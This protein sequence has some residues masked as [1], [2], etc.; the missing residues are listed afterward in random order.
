[1]AQLGMVGLGRM[2]AN[3]VRRLMRDGHDCVVYDVNPDA[4]KELAGE[5]A[6][7]AVSLDELAE[8]LDAPRARLGHGPGRR[9]HREHGR[10]R[11]P[12]CSRSRRRDH[13]RRQL[14][15]PR[16][17]PPRR[18]SSASEGIDYI[19]CGTSGGVFGLERGYC[20]MIGG[21]DAAVERLDP[22]FATH[23]ARASTPPSAPRAA[24]GDP[25]T[26]E[27]GYLHCGP[28]GAG[29]FVKMVHNGIEYGIMAAYAEGLNILKNANAGKVEREADAETAPLEHP[30]YYQYDLD[31]PE[32][33]EVWR[34][35][36]VIGSWLLDL[37]AAALQESPTSTDFAGRVSDSGEGRWTSIAA[38]EEGV[39]AAG[40]H[41]GAL[42]AL[43]LARP[44]RLR[45]Q[46]AL[47]DA[48]AVRRP[49]RE[50]AGVS[51]RR[52][53]VLDDAEAAARARRRADR[54]A[55]PRAAVA[56]RGS[57]ALAVS[58]GRDPW[59]M[60][61]QLERP[62]RWTGTTTEIFQVD[63]RVAPAGDPR[64]QPHPPD[65]EPLD[66]R[67]GQLAPDA[68]HRRRPRGRGRRYDASSCPRRSTSSTSASGPTAT[69]PRWSPATRCS[70]SPTGASRSRRASTRAV[71]RMT[72]TYPALAGRAGCSG[73]SPA[74][75]S[76]TPP[77]ADRPGPVDPLRPGQPGR[78]FAGPR[79]PRRRSRRLVLVLVVAAEPVRLARPPRCAPSA[80]G[81]A[82]RSR[83]SRASRPRAVVT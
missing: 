76:S 71:R 56:E 54:R 57:F 34:R 3:I 37:T 5:G 78:R 70:R 55:R 16:R 33:A 74:R 15:L 45:R 73:W 23:R 65:R 53:E 43:R 80:S 2:G 61:A 35:G 24:T 47:G 52:L 77:E 46:G 42:R 28:S 81:R 21:P 41:H 30:E 27:N 10:T 38:I 22:I 31:I 19:D 6:T 25:D 17:H 14:L 58:G 11:S 64:P 83:P 26:A 67:P 9:D 1:M 20:L 75:R 69:P 63:E 68:G 4:V 40:A 13:R 29:H 79:R 39:P 48:Q 62:A 60:F 51:G 36:S 72:L 12:R 8:K 66:R 59:P 44:R 82:G 50:E 32:V 18:R 49:R 7:G